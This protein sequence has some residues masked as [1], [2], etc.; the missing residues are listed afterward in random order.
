MSGLIEQIETIK[1]IPNSLAIWGFGQMGLGIKTPKSML[2]IDLCLSD[3]L[4]EQFSKIWLRAYPPPLLPEQISNADYYLITH[5]H[6]DHLDPLTVEPLAKA[7]MNAKFVAPAWCKEQ[8]LNLGISEDRLIIPEALKPIVLPDS[9]VT[10]TAVPAAHYEKEFDEEKGYRWFG[11]IIEANGVTVY[12]AGDTIIYDNY[13]DT[14]KQLVTPDI[15]LLPVNGRD[16]FRELEG[17]ATGNLL[18]V[19]AVRLAHDLNW[20]V[21][22]LGHNDLYPFNTIPFSDIIAALEKTAPRQKYKILQPGELYYYVS[23][24]SD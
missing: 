16:Y 17:P 18:P 4:Y 6:A 2:Y 3:I 19:E 24:P 22:M 21:L 9:D 1:I 8:L 13:I 23:N 15:A 7:S 10:L 12:H 5:E 14:L 11:Y 20:D